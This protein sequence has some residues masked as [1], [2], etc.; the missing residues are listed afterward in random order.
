MSQEVDDPRIIRQFL[1]RLTLSF[2]VALPSAFV[3]AVLAF[4]TLPIVDW[5]GL[6]FFQGWGAFLWVELG[7]L[8]LGTTGYLLCWRRMRLRYRGIAQ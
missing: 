1:M 4:L 5:L 8:I 7:A 3:G 6:T 2:L